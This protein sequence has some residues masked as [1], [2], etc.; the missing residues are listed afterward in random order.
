MYTILVHKQFNQMTIRDFF[1]LFSSVKKTYPFTPN[2][3]KAFS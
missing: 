3:K 2:A 1:V